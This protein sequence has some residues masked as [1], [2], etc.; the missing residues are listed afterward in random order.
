MGSTVLWKI[1]LGSEIS[2][3]QLP[4]CHSRFKAKYSHLDSDLSY[5]SVDPDTACLLGGHFSR[6][7]LD[8]QNQSGD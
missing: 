8:L 1:A 5:P 3:E 6:L 7:D 4:H 2:E